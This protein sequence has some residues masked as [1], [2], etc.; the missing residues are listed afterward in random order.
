MVQ[1]YRGHRI[2]V[3]RMNEHLSYWFGRRAEIRY[4]VQRLRDD[5]IVSE[6]GY[7][8]TWMMKEVFIDLRGFV[9]I[10]LGVLDDH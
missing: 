5:V 3:V 8:G 6:G 1:L 10:H 4:R 7:E 9:D 2:E